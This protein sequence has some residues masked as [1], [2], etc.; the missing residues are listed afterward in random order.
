MPNI[1]TQ[2][3]A[4]AVYSA[5]CAL[6]KVGHAARITPV[7]DGQAIQIDQPDPYGPVVLTW[8]AGDMHSEHHASQAAFATAYGLNSD[9]PVK[10]S[11]AGM[12]G[13]SGNMPAPEL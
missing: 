12:F 5:M 9:E 8:W 3:Q 13:T 10:S 11:Y 6:N 2:A 7:F 1:L 4:E